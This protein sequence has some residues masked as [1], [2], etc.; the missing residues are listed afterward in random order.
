[1]SILPQYK[2]LCVISNNI[3]EPVRWT[4]EIPGCSVIFETLKDN[5]A[6]T[7]VCTVRLMM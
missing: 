3:E 2:S 5:E 1:M 6:Y 7:K 4:K